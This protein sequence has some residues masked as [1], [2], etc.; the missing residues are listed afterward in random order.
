MIAHLIKKN[1]P[2]LDI[3]EGDI[4]KSE[5]EIANYP[6]RVDSTKTEKILGFKYISLDKSVVD[7]VNQLI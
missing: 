1:F 7:T 6:W 4:V 3:P 5:E 2:S